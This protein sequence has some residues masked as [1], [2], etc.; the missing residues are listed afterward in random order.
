MTDIQNIGI[1]YIA[2]GAS[3]P[4]IIK[5]GFTNT[6]VE[7]RL[8][9][10]FSTGMWE[11][12]ECV[13]AAKLSNA[14]LWE[15]KL[16]TAFSRFRIRP[17]REFFRMEAAWAITLL[18]GLAIE[19]VTPTQSDLSA[20]PTFGRRPN[21]DYIDCGIPIGAQL[22]HRKSGVICKVIS[23]YE[24]EYENEVYR[25]PKLQKMLGLSQRLNQWFYE[26]RDLDSYYDERH[27][28]YEG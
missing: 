1:I 4:D 16:H 11:P 26:G 13:Y 28:R 22:V 18:R 5:I 23:S 24:V 12:L 25:L 15:Q 19:E 8:S 14:R 10:L 20:T 27:P 7:E 17:D 6:S 9:D 3:H 2:K 21:M